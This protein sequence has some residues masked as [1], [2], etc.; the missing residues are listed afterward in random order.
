MRGESVGDYIEEL[1]GFAGLLSA[2]LNPTAQSLSHAP[3]D[4]SLYWGALLVGFHRFTV[5]GYISPFTVFPIPTA[6]PV[7]RPGWVLGG[8]AFRQR[9]P[10]APSLL[11]FLADMK[12]SRRRHDHITG[13]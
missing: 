8:A 7:G 10:K 6:V 2:S 11:T 9:P 1:Y 4:S 13:F 12:V 5:V 3:R